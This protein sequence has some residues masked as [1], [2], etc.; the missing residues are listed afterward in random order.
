M[1]VCAARRRH[2][3]GTIMTTERRGRYAGS[4]CMG[5][6]RDHLIRLHR[7]NQPPQQQPP[8]VEFLRGRF[9]HILGPPAPSDVGPVFPPPLPARSSA[10][11]Y[12]SAS[13]GGPSLAEM[14][15]KVAQCGRSP[16][17]YGPTLAEFGQFR[18]RFR[19]IRARCFEC[20]AD[21]VNGIW[22]AHTSQLSLSTRRFESESVPRLGDR[23]THQRYQRRGE[24]SSKHCLL[25]P[26]HQVSDRQL[27]QGQRVAKT[28]RMHVMFCE[29]RS[30]SSGTFYGN[31]P[32]VSELFLGV[33]RCA[34]EP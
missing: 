26:T 19:R 24:R 11:T 21:V 7:I 29:L 6:A 23:S 18:A 1:W 2:T 12:R 32:K 5:S 22:D 17:V 15:P 33:K 13:P 28:A 25:D 14:G 27:D 3:I 16:V 34:L 9:R 4:S 31:A 8:K 10:L 20:P 30:P